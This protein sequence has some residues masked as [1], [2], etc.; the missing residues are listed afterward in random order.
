[1]SDVVLVMQ[2]SLN[3][4]KYGINGTSEDCMKKEN[5]MFADVDGVTGVSATDALLIQKFTLKLVDKLTITF[6]Q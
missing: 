6:Y 2:S 3:P 1:M 4:K 5:E